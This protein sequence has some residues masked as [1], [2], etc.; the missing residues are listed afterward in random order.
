MKQPVA[1]TVF[2]GFLSYQIEGVFEIYANSI[3]EWD[4]EFFPY[5]WMANVAKVVSENMINS[6]DRDFLLRILDNELESAKETIKNF[7]A[8]S[9]VENLPIPNENGE[10][11]VRGYK[12]LH[13]EYRKIF[14]C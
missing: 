6:R 10:E 7:I 9:F 14:G 5:L 11:V 8:V 12:N 3:N 4:G 1:E 2:A 13:A